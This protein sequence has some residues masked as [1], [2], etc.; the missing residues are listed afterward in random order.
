MAHRIDLDAEAFP[1]HEA[2][3]HA[4]SFSLPEL[5]IVLREKIITGSSINGYDQRK[6]T[7]LGLCI[8]L[9]QKS[10]KSK[11]QKYLLYYNDRY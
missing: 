4:N 8:K 2:V 9:P 1:L 5:F 10:P 6:C 11:L 3:I 7:P